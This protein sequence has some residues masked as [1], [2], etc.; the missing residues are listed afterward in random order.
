MLTKI[1][2]YE[3]LCCSRCTCSYILYSYNFE[4]GGGGTMT[5]EAW[6]TK[7][8]CGMLLPGNVLTFT[9]HEGDSE[10]IAECSEA[11]QGLVIVM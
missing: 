10:V 5:H 9:F 7:D 4:V 6:I 11:E 2:C 1:S 8:V 3:A